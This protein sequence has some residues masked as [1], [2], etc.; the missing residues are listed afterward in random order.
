M[1]KKF[2]EELIENIMLICIK[3]ARDENLFLCQ[4]NKDGHERVF[5]VKFSYSNGN[6]SHNCNMFEEMDC[7]AIILYGH[8]S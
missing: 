3:G 1:F 2:V 7:Y 8:L 6:I 4:V 5:F